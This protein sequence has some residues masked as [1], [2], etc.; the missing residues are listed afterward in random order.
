MSQHG[1][2]KLNLLNYLSNKL[3]FNNLPG[4][5]YLCHQ[6]QLLFHDNLGGY[7]WVKFLICSF[8]FVWP[9]VGTGIP[10]PWD[11]SPNPK[12]WDWDW[13]W[14]RFF[15]ILGLGLGLGSIFQNFG[16]G[17]GIG[18]DFSKF[19]DWDWAW[20]YKFRTKSQEIPRIPRNPKG[21]CRNFS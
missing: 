13:D 14:D 11:P 5:S 4:F 12:F 9:G 6:V 8:L 16:I 2:E 15:R 21:R 19:W 1:F 7:L 18:I 3:N 17:I 20:D 10:I